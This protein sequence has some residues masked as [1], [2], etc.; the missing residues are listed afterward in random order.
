M[1]PVADSKVVR[2]AEAPRPKR[3]EDET[4]EELK[5]AMQVG[6]RLQERGAYKEALKVFEGVSGS[7]PPRAIEKVDALGAQVT[8]YAA[9]RDLAN[10]RR[11]LN[12][13]R[14]VLPSYPEYVRRAWAS[15]IA[16][17]EKEVERARPE[18]HMP[19]G[20]AGELRGGR[21]R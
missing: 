4:I 2:K 14:A 13:L 11:V 5:R 18:A 7:A 21:G 20:P 19:T 8:C 6:K 10:I 12:Q 17:A 15:W 16:A 1:K 3:P 9:L